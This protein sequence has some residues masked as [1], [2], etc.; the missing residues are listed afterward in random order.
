MNQQRWKSKRYRAIT[1][2]YRPFLKIGSEPILENRDIVEETLQSY[3]YLQ[4]RF[5]KQIEFTFEGPSEPIYTMLNPPY[6]AGRLKIVKMPL[7]R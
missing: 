2:H 7:T 5:S 3:N 4:S 6:T 1:N